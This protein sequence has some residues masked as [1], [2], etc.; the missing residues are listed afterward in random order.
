MDEKKGQEEKEDER[1]RKMIV[2]VMSF[3][4][5]NPKAAFGVQLRRSGSCGVAE[6]PGRSVR[7]TNRWRIVL[8]AFLLLLLE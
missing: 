4:Q 8:R 7:S 3:R 6:A 1:F 2:G 5:G